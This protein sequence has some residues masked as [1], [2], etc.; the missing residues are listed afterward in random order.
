MPEVTVQTDLLEQVACMLRV[1]SATLLED[2]HELLH[3]DR[4]AEN[5][6]GET[7]RSV[8]TQMKFLSFVSCLCTPSHW[9]VK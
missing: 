9:Q 4:L 3:D 1:L 7:N 6:H 8:Q 5:Q 2:K